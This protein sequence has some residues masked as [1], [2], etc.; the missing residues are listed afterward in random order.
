MKEPA[1]TDLT[2]GELLDH[3]RKDLQLDARTDLQVGTVLA[4]LIDNNGQAAFPQLVGQGLVVDH[5][6][7]SR[8]HLA[9][10]QHLLQHHDPPPASS[11]VTC[12]IC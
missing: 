5:L 11:P 4:S 7:R 9:G 6:W 3:L 10:R 8:G 12:T 2:Y 1:L